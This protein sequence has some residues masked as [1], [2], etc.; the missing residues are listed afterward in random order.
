M[1]DG[2]AD[3]GAHILVPVGES[4]T[5]RETVAYA[6]REAQAA[7][8]P[9]ATVHFVYPVRWRTFGPEDVAQE[10]PREL[11]DRI[12]V[13][14]REDLG[15]EDLDAE[16][17]P[18]EVVT[19]VVG[20]DR[21]LFDPGG[22]AEVLAEYAREHGLDRVIVDPEYAPA[23]RVPMLQPMEFELRQ[24]GL[25]VEEAPVERPARRTAL[26]R[27]GG[28]AQFATVFGVS[29]LFY[30]LVGGFAGTFDLVTGAASGLVVASLFYRIVLKE[31]PAFRTWAGQ[32]A[33]FALYVPYLLWEIAWANL[34]LAYVILHPSLPIDPEMVHVE[35]AVWGDLPV[36]TLANSITL[37]PGTLTVDV[38]RREFHVHTLTGSARDDLAAGGLE[39][40]VR[41]VFYGRSAMAIPSPAE[42]DEVVV[43]DE[44]AEGDSRAEWDAGA[45]SADEAGP[46]VAD[47]GERTADEEVSR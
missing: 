32:L 28:A 33:R 40:G 29:Y 7:D 14:T 9:G 13:W 2:S 42:R 23:G 10:G 43:G 15:V 22:Y 11:L 16:D 44:G 24:A 19:A 26:T 18:V 36:T 17:L 45:G 34:Q 38:T 21:Y 39:K 30:L 5:L 20:E 31:P 1:A 35:G 37:T 4:V 6:V 8:D 47:P 25:D 46:G 27:P 12:A 3:A 41:F